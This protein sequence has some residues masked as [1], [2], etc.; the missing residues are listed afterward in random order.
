MA[1][2]YKKLKVSTRHGNEIRGNLEKRKLVTVKHINTGKAQVKIPELTDKAA[3]SLKKQGFEVKLNG[4]RGS[5]EHRYW[6]HRVAEHYRQKGYDVTVEKDL[7]NG[8]RVDVEA[9][10]GK[11]R[12]AIE[13]ETGK[14]DIASNVKRLKGFT[15]IVLVPTTPQAA[16][17]CAAFAKEENITVK[18][19][20]EFILSLVSKGHRRKHRRTRNS[21]NDEH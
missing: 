3:E 10:K 13:V 20:S 4:S 5:L 14:S 17:K 7:G 9:V 2:R 16:E 1:N 11:E 8:K 12:I 19:P 15:H 18:A 21:E 6:V